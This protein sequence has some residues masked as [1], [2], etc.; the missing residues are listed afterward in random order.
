MTHIITYLKG[1]IMVFK[2]KQVVSREA[3]PNRVL[4]MAATSTTRYLLERRESG[5]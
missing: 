1:Y 3:H 4:I 5:L 2:V